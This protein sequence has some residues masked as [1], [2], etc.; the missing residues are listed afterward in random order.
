MGKKARKN[1][2]ENVFRQALDKG[3]WFSFLF[4]AFLMTSAIPLLLLFLGVLATGKIVG[5]VVVALFGGL[6]ARQVV[7]KDLFG[8]C[9]EMAILNLTLWFLLGF[10][11]FFHKLVESTPWY[12]AYI[13]LAPYA[14]ISGYLVFYLFSSAAQDKSRILR[15]G[16]AVSTMMAFISAVNGVAINYLAIISERVAEAGTG[17]ASKVAGVVAQKMHDPSIGF[18]ITL[19][20]FNLP[21]LRHYLKGERRKDLFLYLIPIFLYLTLTGA[22]YALKNVLLGQ[23]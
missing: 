14:L 13:G 15:G 9:R 23:G 21:F 11:T 17:A 16:V 4:F 10:I 7:R 8:L 3:G 5:L 19:V 18:A 12:I 6:L 22:W 20:F 1:E 2:P